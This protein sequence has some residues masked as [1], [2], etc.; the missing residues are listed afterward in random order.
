MYSIALVAITAAAAFKGDLREG[1]VWLTQPGT[2]DEYIQGIPI[3]ERTWSSGG[4]IIVLALFSSMGFF[5]SSCS[6]AITKQFGALTMSITS[7]ARK[8]TTLFLSFFLFQNVCTSEHLAGIILFITALTAK[9]LRRGRRKGRNTKNTTNR[10]FPTTAHRLAALVGDAEMVYPTNKQARLR[11]PTVVLPNDGVSQQ[12]HDE[13]V[14]LIRT[15]SN[16]NTPNRLSHV[17]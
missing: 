15:R 13:T 5:G 17:V 6:A 4:K 11:S 2:Y 14:G 1:L 16:R 3:A 7:T 9:S 12:V 8:A 10:R